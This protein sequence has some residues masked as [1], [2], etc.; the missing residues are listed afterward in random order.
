MGM[1]L[2]KLKL[3]IV[4]E[5]WDSIVMFVLLLIKGYVFF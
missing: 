5:G 3:G 1:K 2:L 4:I